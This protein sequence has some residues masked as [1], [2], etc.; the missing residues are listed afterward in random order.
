MTQTELSTAAMNAA[1]PDNQAGEISPSDVRNAMATALGGYA[2]FV[3][4]VSPTTMLSVT[5]TPTIIDVWDGIAAQ[6]S[7]VNA[8]GATASLTTEKI[9]VGEDGIYFFNFFAS[10]RTGSNNRTVQFQPG[11]NGTP[12]SL[13]IL[14]RIGTASDV[15]TCPY[16]GTFVLTKDDEI[17]MR[18]AVVAGGTTDVLFDGASFSIFRVG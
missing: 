14:Q 7:D 4:T 5:S 18:V 11:V 13:K 15:Q 16:T 1:L 9:T 2:S 6:S 3:Q 10:F 8:A 12:A 17:D